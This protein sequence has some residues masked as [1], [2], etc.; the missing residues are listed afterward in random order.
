MI[1]VADKSQEDSRPRI[2]VG[3]VWY[4]DPSIFR[5]IDSIPEEWE[6]I[7]VDGRFEGSEAPTEYS[8]KY[9]R[10]K[11]RTYKNVTLL[12]FS[13]MEYMSRNKYL[14]SSSCFD[15]CIQIDSDEWIS[16]F[17]EEL[18]YNYVSKLKSGK[19]SIELVPK[20]KWIPKLLINPYRWRYYLSHRLLKYDDGDI[21]SVSRGDSRVNG[22]EISTN[23][24]LRPRELKKYIEDYQ[25][26]LWAYET[27][28]GYDKLV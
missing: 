23:D 15:I 14:E 21:Q 26:K 1:R 24:D 9:L 27:I 11:V 13:G 28:Q 16:Y 3:L 2:C 6:I 20:D 18:F 19:H 22:I 25:D 17:N 7:V 4:E 8:S 10:D 5:T 12:D